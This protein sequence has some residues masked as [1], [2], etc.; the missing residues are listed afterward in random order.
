MA[1]SVIT[2]D[3]QPLIR[4]L[5]TLQQT[6]VPFAASVAL[7]QTAFRVAEQ[8][9]LATT[10]YFQSP[11][12]FTQKGFNY[13]KSTK[14]DLVASVFPEARRARYLNVQISGGG[15]KRKLYE[16]FFRTLSREDLLQV[17]PSKTILDGRGNPRK[18]IFK[19]IQQGLSNA[20][21]SG[22]FIGTPRGRRPG[23][24]ANVPGVYRRGSAG[25]AGKPG[26]PVGSRTG[27]G[28]SSVRTRTLTPIFTVQGR[29]KYEPLFPFYELGNQTANSVW[30]AEFKKALDRA[31]A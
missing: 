26:R 31:T 13:Q 12:P 18:G 9:N 1:G 17:V 30:A 10:Q 28:S 25:P 21:G 5:D 2:F 27:R 24:I 22:F 29:P 20:S 23:G 15:R 11:V 16:S 14:K 19:E 3:L 4:T 7:N 6:Q 8:L